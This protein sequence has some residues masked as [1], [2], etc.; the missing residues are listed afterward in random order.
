MNDNIILSKLMEKDEEY[1]YEIEFKYT[2]T[3]GNAG[4]IL[5]INR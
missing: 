4:N 2:I 5:V 3:A 1:T